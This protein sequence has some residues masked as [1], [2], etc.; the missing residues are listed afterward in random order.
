[1]LRNTIPRL[2]DKPV[3]VFFGFRYRLSYKERNNEHY[4]RLVGSVV[5]EHA[6]SGALLANDGIEGSP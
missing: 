3:E 6:R 2:C 4:P 1:M 5:G